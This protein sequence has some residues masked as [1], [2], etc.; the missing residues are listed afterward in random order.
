MATEPLQIPIHRVTSIS[1]WPKGPYPKM[2]GTLAIAVA[3]L[4]SQL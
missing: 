4:N 2:K 3:I 1:L